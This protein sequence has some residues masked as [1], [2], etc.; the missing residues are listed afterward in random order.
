MGG[1]FHS[2]FGLDL[3]AGLQLAEVTVRG[4]QVK[5]VACRHAENADKL[6][7]RV[8]PAFKVKWLFGVG[9]RDHLFAAAN[10]DFFDPVGLQVNQLVVLKGMTNAAP[11]HDQS[12][13]S[14]DAS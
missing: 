1:K 6:F 11:L 10:V 13:L 12:S 8:I 5:L 9:H 7:Y 3:L 2:F 14:V 4:D